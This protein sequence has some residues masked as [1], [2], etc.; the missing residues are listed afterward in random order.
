[1]FLSFNPFLLLLWIF[2]ANFIPGALISFSIFRKEKFSF[3]EK[4]FIGF[5]IG[6]IVLPLIPFLLYFLGGVN[7]SY[8]IALASIA[9]FYIAALGF[10]AWSRVYEDIKMPSGEKIE[11]TH[12]NLV[13]LSILVVV[14]I[15]FLIRLSSY[16]PVFQE[17]DPY[18]YT[19]TAFQILGVGFNPADDATAW[20]PEV[21]VSH[22]IVPALS[23]LEATWYSLYTGGGELNNLLVTAVASI[24]PPVAAALAVFFLYLFISVTKRREWGVACAAIA[25]FMPILIFKL[26]A[27]EQEVQPYAFFAL[28][29]FFAMYAFAMREKGNYKFAVLAGLGFAAVALGSSSQLLALVSVIL[30]MSAQAVAMFLKEKDEKGIEHLLKTNGIVFLMGPVLGSAVLKDIFRMGNPSLSIFVPFLLALVFVSV[31]YA[32]KKKAKPGQEKI[33]F[34]ALVILSLLVVFATPV[35]DYIINAG[36]AGFQI[37]QF[38]APLDR[39]IAEQGTAGTMLQAQMGFVAESYESIVA[40]ILSPVHAFLSVSS[41]ELADNFVGFLAGVIALPFNI[42]TAI[43]NFALSFSVSALNIVLGSDVV[44]EEKANS[45]LLTWI[46]LFFVALGYSLF[47]YYKDGGDNHFILYAAIILPPLLV[48]IIKAKY[49]IYAGFFLCAAIAFIFQ[50]SEKVIPRFTKSTGENVRSNLIAFAALLVLLQFFFNGFASSLFFGSLTPL[51]QND[52]FATQAKFQ[53]FCAVSNDPEICEA[54]NDPMGFASRGTNYQY[55]EKL[56]ALSI[57]SDYSYFQN[58]YSAPPWELRVVQFRCQRISYYWIESMEWIKENTEKDSRTTSWWDYGHWINFFGERNA[59]LRNEHASHKMIGDVAFSYLDGSPEDLA[60][61]MREHDSKYALFDMEL[62]GMGGQLGGKYGALNYLSCAHMNETS[63]AFSPGESSCEI[64]H[65]WET[66]FI[67]TDAAR[68]QSCEITKDGTKTGIVA[69]KMYLRDG[70]GLMYLLYYPGF[71]INPQN[72]NLLACQNYVVAEPA[73]CVG[74]ITDFIPGSEGP[75]YGTYYLNETYPNGNLK[76]NKGMLQFPGRISNT[77]HFGEATSF[78]MFYTL[79]EIWLE[80]GDMK[81]GYDDRKTK[82]YDS[83]LYRALFINEIPGYRQVFSSSGGEVKIYRLEE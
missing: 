25:S 15:A 68:A 41:V 47:R 22:R 9:F 54:A 78:T 59:V 77:Y 28:S 65:L 17:L 58:F 24:Y 35:G 18:Y 67:P 50:E 62:V 74:D 32:I 69:Y 80:N 29:F 37:A 64:E 33:I 20:Y 63:V 81:S 13:S 30:F 3:L 34:G 44:F 49:T 79:D 71:C 40:F 43:V 19:Y 10:V 8:T 7:F 45:L 36:K 27:G 11:I 31:L 48:G 14:V 5:G 66:I 6:I 26:T 4:L 2:V 56:C 61:F 72:Q 21:E 83:N 82:F 39:T 1:M 12:A 38:N 60:S 55:S 23:Y 53:G 51:Y 57:F 16:S 42:I 76:V 73:Y 75:I 70:N 46:F 52:P